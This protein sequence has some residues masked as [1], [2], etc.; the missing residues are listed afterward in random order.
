MRKAILNSLKLDDVS[1]PEVVRQARDKDANIRKLVYGQVL[2]KATFAEVDGASEPGP[3]HP[4]VLSLSDMES[5]IKKGLRD[6]E[7]GP[8]Q[9]AASLVDEWVKIYEREL[10][11]PEPDQTYHAEVGVISLLERFN[12]IER[13]DEDLEVVEILLESIFSSR[14]DI[15]NGLDFGGEPSASA[16]V[17]SCLTTSQKKTGKSKDRKML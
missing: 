9:A 10:P 4:T 12:I 5:V 16:F 8:R 7:E 15:A 3:S 13:R 17:R 14:K 11:K 6:R 2:K 1:I